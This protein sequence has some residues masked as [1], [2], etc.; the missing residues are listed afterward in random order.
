MFKNILFFSSSTVVVP[1]STKTGPTWHS[2]LALMFLI[3]A[4]SLILSAVVAECL[5]F[6]QRRWETR[7]CALPRSLQFEYFQAAMKINTE[8]CLDIFSLKIKKNIGAVGGL[9]IGIGFIQV[10]CDLRSKYSCLIHSSCSWWGWCSPCTWPT[11]SRRSTRPSRS[12]RRLKKHKIGWKEF[13]F[14]RTNIYS[15]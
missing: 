7:A 8:G 2:P 11:P 13:C 14:P 6:L 10:S 15:Y 9:G 12:D 3:P 4:A 1:R 5:H